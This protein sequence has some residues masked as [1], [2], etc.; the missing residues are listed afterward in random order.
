MARRDAVDSHDP[1]PWMRD[2][3]HLRDGHC[4][5][6]RCQVEARSCDLDHTIPYDQNGPPDQTRPENLACLCRR[7]HRAKTTGRW[8]YLRT[9][10]GDYTWHGPYGTTYLVTDRGTRR[11]P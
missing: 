2:L 9:P 1:P 10:D 7:H 3:V 5:F 4:I 11:L 8:R 6:P